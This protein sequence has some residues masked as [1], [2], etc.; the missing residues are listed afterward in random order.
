MIDKSRSGGTNKPEHRSTAGRTGESPGAKQTATARGTEGEENGQP[1]ASN[2]GL[3][4]SGQFRIGDRI[5]LGVRGADLVL[6]QSHSGREIV[7]AEAA[8]AGL[9]DDTYF[10]DKVD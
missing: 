3:D 2:S 8:L 1:Q 4:V 5:T 6:T 7:V 9:L 10:V